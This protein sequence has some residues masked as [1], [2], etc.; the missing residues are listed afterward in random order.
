[1]KSFKITVVMVTYNRTTIVN[2]ALDCLQNQSYPI[3]NIVV[4]DNASTDSTKEDLL[5]RKEKDARIVLLTREANGGYAAGLEMGIFWALAN[6]ETDFF[7]MMDDDSYPQP[8]ALQLLI[9]G[10][11]KY[12]Y[13]MLGLTGFKM[14]LTTKKTVEPKNEVENVDYILIDNAL[15]KKE[16]ALNVGAPNPDFFMMC[17]DYDY[18]IRIRKS[19]Y[20][21]GV[22]KNNHVNRLHL[23]SQKYS[24]TT[25]WRGYY[26]ARNHLLILQNNFSWFLMFHYLIIQVKYLLGSILAPDRWLRIKL[27]LIGIYHGIIKVKG[28]TLLP[29]TLKFIK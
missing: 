20:K 18:C 8:T 12:D 24:R 1:M 9:E 28:K 6:L 23:G 21:I 2:E 4:I 16:V 11:I 13:D 29:D 17:E 3:E 25:L 10:I 19:G 15:L 27:R 7:W 26:H 14:T 5:K 22:L